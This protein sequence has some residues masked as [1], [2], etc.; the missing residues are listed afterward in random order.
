MTI[1][2]N[3]D[4]RSAWRWFSVQAMTIAAAITAAWA[5]LPAPYTAALPSWVFP[6]LVI[7]VLVLG[8]VGRLVKQEPAA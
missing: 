3:P 5:A 2:F 7:L 4:W 8:V 6:V 1:S